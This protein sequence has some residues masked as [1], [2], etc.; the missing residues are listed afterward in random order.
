M[1]CDKSEMNIFAPAGVQSCIQ[2]SNIVAYSPVSAPTPDSPIE[3][4]I[5]RTGGYKDLTTSYL[6]LTFNI[7]KKDGT[8]LD[9][10]ATSADTLKDPTKTSVA[11]PANYFLHSLFDQVDVYLNNTLVSQS[12]KNY[13]YRAMLEA[14]LHYGVDAKESMLTAAMFHKDDA[15]SI[16]DYQPYK[17]NGNKGLRFRAYLTRSSR[18]VQLVGRL[19]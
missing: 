9:Y 11:T 6:A 1:D 17:A 12:T 18:K 10:D 7:T 16:N 19:H 15:D 13:G 5:P 3:F 8:D 4:V 14:L 2:G